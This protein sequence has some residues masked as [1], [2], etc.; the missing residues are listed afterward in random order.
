MGRSVV[1]GGGESSVASTSSCSS[2]SSSTP[3]RRQR[4]GRRGGA[5][6][7]AVSSLGVRVVEK[8]PFLCFR[9]R[10]TM[11]VRIDLMDLAPHARSKL[12]AAANALLQKGQATNDRLS[13][14]SFEEVG[15]ANKG[16]PPPELRGGGP[17]KVKS[18]WASCRWLMLFAWAFNLFV[19]TYGVA[20]FLYAYLILFAEPSRA[21]W[22][23]A[24]T[25]SFFLSLFLQFVVADISVAALVSCLPLKGRQTTT[26]LS[27][28]CTFLIGLVP[29][30]G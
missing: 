18:K 1:A 15:G 8:L 11:L 12:T 3:I 25:G 19:L 26:P 10:D 23:A 7:I 14:G 20:F 13:V 27:L 4:T 6:V 16:G 5:T 2:T 17:L 22:S 30:A 21:E 9:Q 24:V 29:G 28:I